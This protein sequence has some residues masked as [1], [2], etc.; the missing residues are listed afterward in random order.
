MR[1][2]GVHL[3]PLGVYGMASSTVSPAHRLFNI[4]VLLVCYFAKQ[5]IEDR[6]VLSSVFFFFFFLRRGKLLVLVE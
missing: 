3:E 4:S 2:S 1:A 5:K 6:C